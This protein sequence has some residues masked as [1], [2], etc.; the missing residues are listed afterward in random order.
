MKRSVRT[1]LIIFLLV[2]C[3]LT[4]M[5]RV[6]ASSDKD[7]ETRAIAIVFDNSGS[8]YD[9]GD[10]SWCRATYAMEVFAS[11]LNE[12]DTLLIYPMHPIQVGDKEYT[13]DDPFR[14]T[15]ASQ[16]SEIRD[17][18]TPIA[19]GTPIESVDRAAEGLKD[20]RADKKYMIVLTDGDS[21][22]QYGFPMSAY[23]TKYQL[24][25]RFQ[26]LAGKDMTV[27]YLGVG[28]AVVMP[29]TPQSEYFVKKQAQNSTDVLSSL[30]D[31]CNLIFGRD[32][33]PKNHLSGN[34]MDFDISMKKL[35]VFVQ[36]E[37]VS[38]V[39]VTGS[40][41]LVGKQLS[42][43]TTKYGTAGCGN[44]DSAPDTSL[45]GMMVTYTD[46]T[47]GSYTLNYSGTATNVEVY[48]EPDA[49]LDFVF[50]DA[51]GNN[52]DPQ[53]LYE[54]EYKLSF[55]LKDAKTGKLISS[56]LLGDA[57]YQG[58]YFINGE[59]FT[60]THDGY[61]GE[62]P[63]TLNMDDTFGAN[64]T[65]TYLSGYTIAKDSSDFGWPDGGIK[66][67][68]RPA[69]E[70]TL[71]I[72]GGDEDYS[73]PALEE[74]GP[75]IA[76]VYYQG[77]QLTGDELESVEL[78]W[79]PNTSNAEIQKEFADDHWKLSLHYKDPA[80]PQDTVCGECTVA[81]YAFYT[82]QGSS[83]AQTQ[84][85]LTYK[86]TEDA[87]ALRVDV[88]APEDYIVIGELEDS[89]AVVVKLTLNGKPLTP[90]EFAAVEM[91]VNCSGIKHNIT[92]RE[93][94]STYLIQLLPTDGIEEDD[95]PIEVT[96]QYTDPIGRT[97]QAEDAAN[98]TL[99]NTPLWL[100]WV[101]GLLILLFLI[102]LIWRIMHIKKF[103]S[104]VRP[105]TDECTLNVGG[106][107][108]T[109]NATFS[110]K[111]S[112]KQ[113]VTYVEY[114]GDQI[115][116]VTYRELAPGKDSYLCKP[117]HK[118]SI[119]AKR[120]TDINASGDVTS[121]EIGSIGYSLDKHGTLVPDDENQTAYTISNGCVITVRGKIPVGGKDKN[122]TAEI[123]LSFKK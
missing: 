77:V 10:Q 75:Y 81:I 122:Y 42:S 13:M 49:D 115:G 60:I 46:C 29:D 45:Q 121:V 56:D 9:D 8:M 105:V 117:S 22:Y 93:Q 78:K 26:A 111:L 114:N 27:M 11:M 91:Q 2:A 23:D 38:D 116:R 57:H 16:A 92:C 50:T 15:N 32:T 83:Q 72:T 88:F 68:A 84:T 102:F 35:I 100:K 18:Y 34:A 64:L 85:D 5:P 101:I 21:F 6:Y 103:P 19:L 94:D 82:A 33:L 120:P 112:G 104:R 97:A 40:S 54:G 65:V 108:E 71:E 12:G 118:R 74:G 96:A 59:E 31:M 80:A 7:N 28:S 106:R 99:S 98:V 86:I 17:I 113:L 52:V 63:I 123:P 119:L 67:A 47:A 43:S 95:Y 41:G 53:A 25:T 39:K 62:V 44:Y 14:V 110:A 109:S 37:N 73:L 48:Y 69:G 70:L 51:A 107:D 3:V 90:E 4:G 20:I 58:S 87:F 30:T 55:G 1:I 66:V 24:D 36:G 89:Q 76:Q 79:N 61:S